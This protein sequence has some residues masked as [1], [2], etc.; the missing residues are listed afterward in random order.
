MNSA[1]QND[2]VKAFE[3]KKIVRMVW[4]RDGEHHK[5][6]DCTRCGLNLLDVPDSFRCDTCGWSYKS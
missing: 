4:G 6:G 3:K 2:A 5:F 1:K